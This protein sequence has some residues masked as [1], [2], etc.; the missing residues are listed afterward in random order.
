MIRVSKR[1]GRGAGYL[2]ALER[3]NSV[4]RP[5][6]FCE[7]DKVKFFAVLSPNLKCC[8]S[9]VIGTLIFYENIL[10]ISIFGKLLST[11]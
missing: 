4:P 7:A 11:L 10:F 2:K 8:D 6:E 9:R 1:G 3:G 5:K